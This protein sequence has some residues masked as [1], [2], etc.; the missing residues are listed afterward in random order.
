[1]APIENFIV[2]KCACESNS[3]CRLDLRRHII[4]LGEFWQD[5]E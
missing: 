3:F 1:M 2:I 5:R 4:V